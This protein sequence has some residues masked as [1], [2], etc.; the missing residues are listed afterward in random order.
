MMRTIRASMR[1]TDVF[2]NKKRVAHDLDA[3]LQS[4][5]EFRMED[6]PRFGITPEGAGP[7]TL[8]KLARIDQTKAS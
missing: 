8:I 2:K 5:L 7:Q 1:V 3:E 4:H 6:N